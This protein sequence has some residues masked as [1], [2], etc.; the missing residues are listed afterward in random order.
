VPTNGLVG[1]WSFNGN[2][3]DE[4]GNGNN[5]TVNGAI[6]ATDRFYKNNQAYQFNGSPQYI[7]LGNKILGSNP[8]SYS[9]SVWT[10]LDSLYTGLFG[11]TS[12]ILTKRHEDIG[13]SWSTLQINSDSLI[14]YC[15]DGPGF[16]VG[17]QSKNKCIDKHWYHIVSNKI[18][19]K[20][21]LYINSI[22]I[23][24]TVID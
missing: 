7:D 24:D 5:G 17:L 22:L 6:S 14:R 20:Y 13:V 19:N 10:K 8:H 23:M 18:G 2:A 21:Q 4:S 11:T 16:N 1:W 12:V 9:Y 15:V 3:N